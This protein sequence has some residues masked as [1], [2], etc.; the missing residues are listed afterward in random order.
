MQIIKIFLNSATSSGTFNINLYTRKKNKGDK[1]APVIMLENIPAVKHMAT[2][3]I[4]SAYK[5]SLNKPLIIKLNSA[6][7]KADARQRIIIFRFCILSIN[8]L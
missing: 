6:F 2:V 8:A 3:K 7:A 4:V 5:G 1:K